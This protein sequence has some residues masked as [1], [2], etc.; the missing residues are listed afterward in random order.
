MGVRR[1]LAL[2]E[3]AHARS[4][5]IDRDWPDGRGAS[6]G[7]VI[8]RIYIQKWGKV[9]EKVVRRSRTEESEGNNCVLDLW[10][11]IEKNSPGLGGIITIESMGSS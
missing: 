6:Q 11:S 7:S 10:T 8:W 5:R 1:G 3:A 4:P 9:C 2:R